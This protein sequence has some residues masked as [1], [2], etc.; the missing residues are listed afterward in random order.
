M[1]RSFNGGNRWRRVAGLVIGRCPQSLAVGGVERGQPGCQAADIH[2]YPA[3]IYQGRSGGAKESLG[4][5]E[6]PTRVQAPDLLPRGEI[7]AVQSALRAEGVDAPSSHG[8][9]RAR[10]FVKAE[11]VSV[12][13]GIFEG[14]DG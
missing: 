8:R 11:V 12:L 14:P 10:S 3:A 2:P 13:C 7:E 1:A 9:R 5:L 4:H 6:F